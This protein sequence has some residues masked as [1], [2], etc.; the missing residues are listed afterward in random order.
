LPTV[1]IQGRVKVLF[2]PAFRFDGV[3]LKLTS[4]Q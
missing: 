2:G 1:T 3:L 4:T